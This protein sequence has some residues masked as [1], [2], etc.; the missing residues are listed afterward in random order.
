MLC[1]LLFVLSHAQQADS[2]KKDSLGSAR[3][4]VNVNVSNVKAASDIKKDV[5]S[6][7][8]SPTQP[9]KTVNSNAK[10]ASDSKR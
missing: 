6:V 7:S 9:V 1:S 10:V 8:H 5:Q 3:P 4:L 2:D